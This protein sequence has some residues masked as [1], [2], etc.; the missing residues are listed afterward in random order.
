MAAP[1]IYYGRCQGRG[2]WR[3]RRSTPRPIE[4]QVSVTVTWALSSSRAVTVTVRDRQ[5]A[6]A[7]E[8]LRRDLHPGRGLPPLVLGAIDH[9]RTRSTVARSNPAG[10]MSSTPSRPRRRPR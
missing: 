7:P 1:P 9:P 3:R 2:R 10:T 5:A 4:T 8:R 6:V